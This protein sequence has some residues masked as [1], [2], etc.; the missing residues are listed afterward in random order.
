[1]LNRLLREAALTEDPA[2]LEVLSRELQKRGFG[3][4][5]YERFVE[6]R[7]QVGTFERFYFHEGPW[8]G[9]LAV[10]DV[11]PE[12]LMWFLVSEKGE[13]WVRRAVRVFQE[14]LALGDF[15]MPGSWASFGWLLRWQAS[16]EEMRTERVPSHDSVFLNEHF[17]TFAEV[18]LSDLERMQVVTKTLED[19]SECQIRLSLQV[20]ELVTVETVLWSFLEEGSDLTL[21]L[22]AET[23]RRSL[24]MR[25]EGMKK[26]MRYV[27][28]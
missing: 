9:S 18:L 20:G 23:Y 24:R 19:A 27:G 25:I 10:G 1:M 4:G 17:A 5:V 13:P 16:L 28:L 3:G 2:T 15:V 6:M 14:D 7:H 21:N 8:W 26:G 22:H 12:S 11:I